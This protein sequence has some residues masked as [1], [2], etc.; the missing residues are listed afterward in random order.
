MG[1]SKYAKPEL[2]L[3]FAHADAT[4]FASLLESPRG[5]GLA[6]E[7]ILLLT[8]Q[9]ATTAA[10][11]NGFQ[12][13]LKRRATKKDTVI[14]LV[15][16]HGIA[17]GKDAF[18]VTYDSDPQDLKSTGL[19]MAELQT[20][21]QEQV[22][23]VGRVLLF[24]DVCK[25]DTIGTI[26]SNAVNAGVENFKNVEGDLLAMMSARRKELSFEGPE[27]GGGHGAFSYFLLK[28][29]AGAADENGDG[30]VDGEELASY[31]SNNVPKVTNGHQHPTNISPGSVNFKL[32]D[33]KKPGINMAR[34]LIDSRNG[35]PRLVASTT[36]EPAFLEEQ[37]ADDVDRFTEAINS[38]RI[39]PDQSDNAFTALQKL[40]S[41]LDCG[42][43][44]A[45]RESASS[46]PGE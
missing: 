43:V 12:D 44:Q 25:A 34:K 16:G 5:G 27:F 23:Q 30:V 8:D 17:D 10:V 3:Q 7:N 29:L 39:L 9:G 1:I 20:L 40:K 37:V 18:I 41:E 36:A 14:I 11:R 22:A 24:V 21:F 19:P 31:V 46:C 28:G 33:L 38:G 6:H 13:F 15:A 32:S 45:A 26:K 4:T 35:Q 42:A 2:N